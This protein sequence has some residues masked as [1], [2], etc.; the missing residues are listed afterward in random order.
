[1]GV[2][3]TLFLVGLISVGV[4]TTPGTAYRLKH[5]QDLGLIPTPSYDRRR[6]VAALQDV[7]PL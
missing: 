7:I 5:P 1:M 3:R 2:D 6:L 4:Y